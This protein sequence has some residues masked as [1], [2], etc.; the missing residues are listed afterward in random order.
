MTH[1]IVIYAIRTNRPNI[2]GLPH[3]LVNILDNKRI[4]RKAKSMALVQQSIASLRIVLASGSKQRLALLK[5][6]V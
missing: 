4:R 2:S 5:Q 6:I 3:E 1:F